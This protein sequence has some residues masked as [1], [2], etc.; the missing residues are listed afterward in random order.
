MMQRGNF[1]T[2][3]RDFGW[4]DRG[5]HHAGLGPALGE[6]AAPRIDDERMAKGL[7]PVLVLA[8]LRGANTKQPFSIARARNSIASAPGRSAG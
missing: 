8:G 1:C 4:I 7:A 6:D 5:E 2:R 3:G